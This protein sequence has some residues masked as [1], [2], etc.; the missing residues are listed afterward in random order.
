MSC[1]KGCVSN[2]QE[3]SILLLTVTATAVVLGFVITKEAWLNYFFFF[4]IKKKSKVVYV[5]SF[6]NQTAGRIYDENYSSLP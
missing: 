1:E 4:H 2:K 6:K 3:D 5:Y